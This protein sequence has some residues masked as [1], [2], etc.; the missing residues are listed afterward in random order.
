MIVLGYCISISDILDIF[1]TFVVFPYHLCTRFYSDVCW[2]AT[3][4]AHLLQSI[5]TEWRNGQC[6][7]V[8]RL[9]LFV[10]RSLARKLWRS[11]LVAIQLNFKVTDESN[12]KTKKIDHY[13]YRGQTKDGKRMFWFC[14]FKGNL[15]KCDFFTLK[16]AFVNCG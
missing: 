2:R 3:V 1:I 16:I 9:G 4:T 5:E 15:T 6:Y 14:F 11:I 12:T 10:C 13:H 7:W 8:L